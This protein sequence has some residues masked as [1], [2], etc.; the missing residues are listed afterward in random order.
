MF[1]FYIFNSSFDEYLL[2]HLILIFDIIHNYM[3]CTIHLY[4]LVFSD[5]KYP[6]PLL[7][8]NTNYYIK[9]L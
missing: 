2:N 1:H 3:V 4:V 6:Y 7:F 5:Q 8:F 9:Q